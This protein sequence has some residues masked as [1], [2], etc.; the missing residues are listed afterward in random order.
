MKKFKVPI[1]TEEY[2]VIVVIGARK[3]IIKFISKYTGSTIQ[4]VEIFFTDYCS[5]LCWNCL[6]NNHPLIAVDGQLNAFKQISTI[7]HEA[8]HAMDY[9]ADHIK[10]E[11]TEFRAHGIASIMRH[12]FKNIKYKK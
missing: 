5:G 2:S 12:I 11:H 9:I 4:E 1:F 7:A 10:L 8:A 3:D 6:P